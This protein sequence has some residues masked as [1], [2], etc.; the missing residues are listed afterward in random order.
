MMEGS[1]FELEEGCCGGRDRFVG[2]MESRAAGGGGGGAE[3]L[4]V[5]ALVA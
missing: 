2:A 1:C 3:G 4:V 5:V